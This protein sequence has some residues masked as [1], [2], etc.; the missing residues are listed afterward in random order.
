MVAAARFLC[1]GCSQAAACGKRG[2]GPRHTDRAAATPPDFPWQ[3]TLFTVLFNNADSIR[4][5]VKADP[6]YFG[7]S[8]AG[9]LNGK[10]T[11]D[12]TEGVGVTLRCPDPTPQ[13][14]PGSR[15]AAPRVD[16]AQA[17][18]SRRKEAKSLIE[19]IDLG[20]A[21]ALHQF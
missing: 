1:R 5:S 19:M 16:L 9:S 7:A 2:K 10:E 20:R 3:S 21:E 13:S 4:R 14:K 12:A 15:H 8:P 11:S 18:K 17:E 6:R